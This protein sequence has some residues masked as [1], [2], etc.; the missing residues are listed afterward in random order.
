MHISLIITFRV[1][2]YH[3]IV[4]AARIRNE[5][6][7]PQ[8]ETPGETKRGEKRKQDGGAAGKMTVTESGGAGFTFAFLFFL[9]R[10]HWEIVDFFGPESKAE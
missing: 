9:V 2:N 8:C 10:D 6:R 3:P 4:I 1:L 7:S 5:T